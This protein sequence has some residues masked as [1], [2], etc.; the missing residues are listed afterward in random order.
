MDMNT[1]IT[2][3]GSIAAMAGTAFGI[4]K[5]VGN[6]KKQLVVAQAA[7]TA[8]KAGADGALQILTEVIAASDRNTL[9]AEDMTQIISTASDIPGAIKTALKIASV[10]GQPGNATLPV[11]SVQPTVAAVPGV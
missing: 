6:Y 8:V 11:A 1:I 7:L 10:P 4:L 3:I 9:T 2:G 5:W